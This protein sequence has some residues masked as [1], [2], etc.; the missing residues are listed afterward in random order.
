ME[1]Y[2]PSWLDTLFQ[3]Y[4]LRWLGRGKQKVTL[5]FPSDDELLFA[6]GEPPAEE[7][8]E[9]R[10]EARLR[11][12]ERGLGFFD[13]VDSTGLGTA[14]V[15]E[16]LWSL[17]WRGRVASDS[18]ETVR[19]GIV[20]AFAPEEVKST[21]ASGRAGF[22]RWERSRPSAGTWH[23]LPDRQPKGAM[24][25][26]E[27]E[28][29]RARLVL[30]RYGVIFREL[31]EHELP[32]L[33]WSRLFRALRLLELSGE[34]LSGHFFTGVP[35]IQFAIPEAIRALT[36]PL[37]GARTYIVH[38]CDPASV[39]GL[40]LDELPPHLPRRTSSNWTVWHESALVLVLQKDG[41]ELFVE[42][43]P[44]DPRLAPALAI[45]RLLLGREFSPLSSVTVETVNQVATPN[46]PY[47][48]DLRQA[49]F[50]NDYRGMTLWKRA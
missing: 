50:V 44:A 40:G 22:R 16:S 29:E 30:A 11:Q 46:S 38:A 35:G 33:R 13:L 42:F 5:A 41:R 17:A 24:E 8:A 18:F 15:A 3:S 9:A 28:K 45:Y 31:L 12:S 36:D 27:L 34:I 47:A 20:S 7:S 6:T 39:C 21:G 1:T 49:G 37:P 26:A 32:L 23:V 4:G 48:T 10:L 14:A 2:Y 25:N 19:R 43:E